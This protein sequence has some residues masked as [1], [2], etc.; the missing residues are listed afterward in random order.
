[1]TRSDSAVLPLYQSIRTTPVVIDDDG[2]AQ[3][4]VD[5]LFAHE[6]GAELRPLIEAANVRT[7]LEG[8]V[9]TSPYLS[10]LVMRD[11]AR[12]VRVLSSPPDQRFAELK[13][14]LAEALEAAD[15]QDAAMSALRIFKNEVALLAGLADVADVWPVMHVTRVLSE[16]ADAALQGVIAF[17]FRQAVRSGKWLDTTSDTAQRSGYFVL[18]MGKHGAFE[19]NYSSDIDLIVFYDRDKAREHLADSGE[20][21]NFFIRFTRDLVSL[22]QERTADGYVFRTDLRLRPDPGSTPI[23]LPTAA[24]LSYYESTGQNWERAAMIKA[25]CVAGDFTAGTSFLEEIRPFIWR[26][27]LDFAA[28]SDIHA[29]KRQIHTFR[30]FGNIA[31][32]G[33]NIKLGRGGIREIEFFA[34]TQQLIAGGRQPGLRQRAT[35]DTLATLAEQGWIFEDVRADLDQAY[36]YLR[37]LEHR[38]QMIN[39]EQTHTMPT[40]MAALERLAR[41]CGLEDSDVLASELLL[42]LGHVQKHYAALFEDTPELTTRSKDLVFAG[43]DDDP[44]TLETLHEMGFS[45]PKDVMAMVKS[46]HTGRYPAMR[47]TQ[48]REKLTIVQ[49]LLIEQ[50]S[51]TADPDRAL[52]TFDRFLSELPAGIQLFSLLNQHP[53]LL[54]LLSDIMGTAPRLASILSR[55][56]RLLDAVIDPSTFDPEALTENLDCVVAAEIGRATDFQEVLD[57]SRIVGSEQA[58]LIGVRVLSGSIGAQRAGAAYARLAERMID[59]LTIEAEKDLGIRHGSVPGGETAVVA[60]GK[61]GG[62]EMTA[63]SDLDLI[64]VY[65]YPEGVMQSDGQRPIDCST[66]YTRFT[67][68]L[69]NALTAPTVEG[70]LYEVDLRLRPSGNQG[71]VATRLQSFIDYQADKAWTWEH[72]ALT[73]ARVVSGPES[74]RT[75]VEAAIHQALIQPRE[76][77]KLAADVLEM[78]AR[79]EKDKGTDD[80]WDLKMVRGGLVDLEFIAQYLQLLHAAE[81]PD[82]LA[83]NTV[84]AFGNLKQANVLASEDAELL[85]AAALKIQ[86]LT[87][88]LRLCLAGPMQSEKCPK[89]LLEMLA[90]AGDA[91]NF[92]ILE[93]ELKQ[94]LKAT[95]QAFD[96]LVV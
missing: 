17:L 84:E 66:Y 11:V 41:F 43:S 49:P 35:L 71:P 27:H 57:R 82:V 20:V 65:D 12:L 81:I 7:L 28:I 22:M 70:A 21:Q 5:D 53:R 96:R 23:A 95:H 63:A 52:V 51:E 45:R 46:W 38:L 30:G 44:S 92:K 4:A 18:A 58:F 33:H 55:R 91:P 86:N 74:F 76:R 36:Q 13:H 83:T 6:E 1:M 34:Q 93:T 42:H 90:R 24:A 37:R 85:T 67:Q 77:A 2:H 16:T 69:I 29:M 59:A 10:N 78:R 62:V 94:T 72:M 48:A 79:I 75:S 61:L 15:T 88:V 54:R 39:D 68:R 50:L 56:R 73:R 47:S 80:I 26:R 60:M 64:V 31:V 32:A 8:L 14:E 87:Q 19:L 3:R 9:Q 25:R 89:G 40:D